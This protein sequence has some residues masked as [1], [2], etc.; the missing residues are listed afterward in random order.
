MIIIK[1]GEDSQRN[2]WVLIEIPVR[3][4]FLFFSLS[5][6]FIFFIFPHFSL[7]SLPF[8][9]FLFFIY[10]LLILSLLTFHHFIFSHLVSIYSCLSFS[11]FQSFSCHQGTRQH[12][13]VSLLWSL[14]LHEV[15]RLLFCL[16]WQI[17]VMY[18]RSWFIR[19]HWKYSQWECRKVLYIRLP[20]FTFS[21]NQILQPNC[22]F[23]SVG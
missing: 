6:P 20:Y 23:N 17:L 12:R 16:F 21:L 9:S 14:L 5:H 11:Y 19:H 7:I 22:I 3:I 8:S 15:I 1:T 13:V 4:S 18:D 10:R 2:V